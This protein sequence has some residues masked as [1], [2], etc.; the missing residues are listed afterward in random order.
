[1]SGLSK[2]ASKSVSKVLVLGLILSG[3]GFAGLSIASS[4]GANFGANFGADSIAKVPLNKYGAV[5]VNAHVPI[6]VQIPPAPADQVNPMPAS[7]VNKF[8]ALLPSQPNLG[9][10]SY[11]LMDANSGQVIAEKD[12]YTRQPPAS[13]A[14]LMLLYIIEQQLASGDLK[15]DQQIR[16]PRVAWATG[17]SRMFL[18]EHSYV[19]VSDL[20]QG[21]VVASGNDAA[22]TLAMHIAGTQ[23][24][25]VHMMNME[26]QKLGMKNTH[27]AT[28]M[29]LPAPNEYTCAY[30]LGLLGRAVA[31]DYPQYFSWFGQKMFVYKDIKQPNYNKL[32]FI[33]PNATGMKTGS[34]SYAGYSLVG[35]A[36]KVNLDT[37]KPMRLIAVVLGAKNRMDSAT[38]AKALL[39]YGF[40]FFKTKEFFAH[41]LILKK[42][43]VYSGEQD[44]LKVGLNEPVVI[45][46][47]EDL[48]HKLR[49]TLV[50]NK[51]IKAPIHKGKK[52]GELIFF[53]NQDQNQDQDQDQDQDQKQNKSYTQVNTKNI[54]ASQVSGVIIYKAPVF[55]QHGILKGGFFKRFIDSIKLKF[56]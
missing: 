37:K 45:T 12:A 18:K 52:V 8:S 39:Q 33:Y 15:L 9:V 53:I 21:I 13:I 32:L 24:A 51:T 7:L 6:E 56:S 50:M 3:F 20:I 48:K 16:V 25:F 40:H 41:K 10:R 49:A 30:D 27:Y 28:V 55:A 44:D 5:D 35:S 19:K 17:G 14:K 38:G 2:L 43:R 47:P 36:E 1:M 54:M 4:S 23:N 11:L 22:V 34:T 29:G 42:V 26:A 31:L 46:Y